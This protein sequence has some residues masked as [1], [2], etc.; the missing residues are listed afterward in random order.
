M[1]LAERISNI[2][3]TALP[4]DA[5]AFRPEQSAVES[6]RH[7][8]ALVDLA[9]ERLREAHR[10]R[11]LAQTALRAAEDRVGKAREVIDEAD[12]ADVAS[13]E[14]QRA[15]K[16][17]AQD[18]VASGSPQDARP[19]PG[20]LKRAGVAFDAAIDARCVAD[21]AQEALPLLLQT[22]EDARNALGQADEALRAAVVAVLAARVEPTFIE[23]ARA[24]DRYREALRPALY[25]R[26]LVRT[27]G[28]AHPLHGFSNSRL[29]AAIDARLRD[30]A[31]D[32]PPEVDVVGGAHDVLAEAKR[33]LAER[34]WT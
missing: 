21:G 7:C 24:R 28:P 1:S 32:S 4:Q 13:S 3:R 5:G 33:L 10:G 25:L 29:A 19:D 17:A 8:E 27:W 16:S 14:T 2:V 18:W 11:G 12:R 15:A 20:L 31:I 22:E 6:E 23:L 34:E 26:H 9:L 30:L